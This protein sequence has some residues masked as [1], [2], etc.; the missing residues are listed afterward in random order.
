LRPDSERIALLVAETALAAGVPPEGVQIVRSPYR[1]CP[2]G[3]HVDHQLGEVTGMALDR[4][5]YLAFVP[6]EEAAVSVRSRNFAGPVKFRFSDMPARPQGDWGDYLRGAVHALRRRGELRRGLTAIVDGGENVGGLSSSAAVGVAYLL[7]LERA[8]AIEV[9]PRENIELDRIIEN[10]Y[11][12]LNN[13]LLDQSTILLSRRGR[14]MHLD[15]LTGK[16]ELHE[17]GARAELWIAVLYSGLQRQ[18]SDT[19]YNRRVAECEEAARRL[20]EAE[21][22]AP[23]PRP[24]LRSVP[25]E[26]FEKHQEALP[27][28]LRR[29]ARHFFSEQRRVREG[30]VL[31]RAGDL[32]GFGR[33]VTES[34][35]SSVENY[36]CGNRYL[37]TAW[38]VLR[39]TPGML[40]ARFSGA[41][42]R[43]C[44]IGLMAGPPDEG[45]GTDILRRYL[46]AH[47][48][49]DGKAEVTFC[50]PADGAG[51]VG[52]ADCG[53]QNAE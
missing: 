4:A 30:V 1:I 24:K 18:L 39:D 46:E 44:S 15:C 37:R 14:L 17:C 53:M 49:M 11:I 9:S 36:E 7:A 50:R 2:L 40:G 48:D 41:G 16:T 52:I 3:A 19:D 28:T 25:A 35:Q 21:G 20:L 8:N 47:P 42:F 34:G 5:L 33:L 38:A 10:E 26:A 22:M 43:G 31:W 23:G 29:R 32:A 51:F 13:G 45:V 27:E 6:R 12:G